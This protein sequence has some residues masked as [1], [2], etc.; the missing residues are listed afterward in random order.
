MKRVLVVKYD[1][2]NNQYV[3]HKEGACGMYIEGRGASPLEAIGCW[4]IYSQ[5]VE[6]RCDPPKL[7]RGFYVD[8]GKSVIVLKPADRRD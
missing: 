2:E 3:C 4:C 8:V 1:E 5:K 7:L 6:A